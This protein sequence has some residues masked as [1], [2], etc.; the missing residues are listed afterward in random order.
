MDPSEVEFLAEKEKISIQTNFSEDKIYLIGVGVF[1][2]KEERYK[3]ILLFLMRRRD[4]F[5]TMA[6]CQGYSFD[7]CCCGCYSWSNSV[8]VHCMP[9]SNGQLDHNFLCYFHFLTQFILSDL[10]G[11]IGPF[12]ASLPTE[13]PLWVAIFLK[14]RRKC[15]ILPPDW[16]DVGNMLFSAQI[17][18]SFFFQYQ[19]RH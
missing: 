7:H 15:R 6:F 2:T 13:V 8:Y 1:T 9:A 3:W 4:I 19:K 18:S 17:T 14:Q 5:S 11:D 12:N 10:Q 16:M